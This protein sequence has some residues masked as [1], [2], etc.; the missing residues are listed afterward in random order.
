MT[1]RRA[2]IGENPLDALVPR[3]PKAER[4]GFSSGLSE[5]PSVKAEKIEKLRLTVHVPADLADR[6]KNAVYWTPG[7]TLARLAEEA[8]EWKVSQM[9]EERGEQFPPRQEELKGGRPLK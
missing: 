9:E 3:G 1:K 2:T 5:E 6:V 7:M 4:P 8:L